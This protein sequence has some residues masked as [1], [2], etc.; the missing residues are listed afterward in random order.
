MTGVRLKH[1]LIHKLV[2][3]NLQHSSLIRMMQRTLKVSINL[4]LSKLFFYATYDRHNSFDV[5]VKDVSFLK[6][7]KC[8]LA[9]LG[10]NFG[11][12]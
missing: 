12:L 2:M 5:L 7:L 9:L 10:T 6:T 11:L 3:V 1:S 4:L 8:N